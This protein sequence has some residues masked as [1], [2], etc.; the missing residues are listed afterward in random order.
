M[1]PAPDDDDDDDECDDVR[2]VESPP[3]FDSCWKVE[4]ATWAIISSSTNVC[5]IDWNWDS[6]ILPPPPPPPGGRSS[7]ASLALALALALAAAAVT[8]TGVWNRN[9]QYRNV[10]RQNGRSILLYKLFD[11]VLGLVRLVLL[12]V[13]VGGCCFCHFW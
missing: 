10:V 7:S 11:L 2:V 9:K 13:V 12:V 5:S 3:L 8:L 6:V 4:S 1:A